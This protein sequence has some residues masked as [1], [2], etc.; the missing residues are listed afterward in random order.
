SDFFYYDLFSWQDSQEPI[1]DIHLSARSFTYPRSSEF[2]LEKVE[3]TPAIELSLAYS[4]G[5]GRE[6]QAK[7]Y[8]DQPD[9]VVRYWDPSTQSVKEKTQ[10]TAWLTT[11]ATQY[12]N[13]GNVIQ[14][15]EPFYSNTYA[16]IDQQALNQVGYSST[17]FYDALDREIMVL[18]PKQY[19][20][21]SLYG[22]LQA[23]SP[24]QETGYLAQELYNT[25]P[26]TYYP[27]SW[28]SL[29]FDVNDAIQDSPY[30]QSASASEQ[31][32][33]KTLPYNTPMFAYTDGLG[34]LI[35]QEQLKVSSNEQNDTYWQR[36]I[37]GNTLKASDGRLLPQGLYNF[38]TTY[39]L[40]KQPMQSASV[41]AGTTWDLW[42]VNEN[43]VY[44]KDAR[45]YETRRLYD[46]L[47]RMIAETV[48]NQELE[49]P[50]SFKSQYVV[51]GESFSSPA[52]WNRRGIP[53]I[54]F[55]QSGLDIVAFQTIDGQ[56]LSALKALCTDFKQSPDWSGINETITNE[57]IQSIE[58]ISNPSETSEINVSMVPKL[59]QE[60]YTTQ[61][62]YNAVDETIEEI[63]PDGNVTS[64]VY[65][66]NG[67]MKNSQID[68]GPS[69]D[70]ITYNARGQRA[71]VNYGNQVVK[72]YSYDPINF[73][74]TQIKSVYTPNEKVIQDYSYTYD[75]LGNVWSLTRNNVP[76]TFFN[77][78]EVKAKAN[79]TYDS[80][81]RLV[82][83]NGRE[84]AGNALSLQQ[85]LLDRSD[86]QY[87]PIPQPNNNGQALQN[88]SEAFT[89]DEGG[90]LTQIKHTGT[91]S[92]TRTHTIQSD[93]NRLKNSVI[94]GE[95]S[96]KKTYAYDA[97]GNMTNLEGA[98][99]WQ[100]NE[101]N[102][103][104][105]AVFV[106]RNSQPD[107][108]EY[109]VYDA[110]GMRVRKVFEKMNNGGKSVTLTDVV[111][112][113]NYE[114]RR[115]Y[116]QAVGTG[117]KT[118]KTDWRVHRFYDGEGCVALWRYYVENGERATSPDQ[119]Q[120]R[121][122]LQDHL[123][124]SNM[125]VDTEGNL[126]TYQEYYPFGGTAIMAGTSQTEVNAKYYQYSF[127][128][129]D[130]TTGLYYY[131]MRYYPSWLGRWINPDPAGTV[132]GLNIYA[133]V[134][135]DPTT[136]MDVGGMT[137]LPKDADSDIDIAMH[138]R[139]KRKNS[140]VNYAD[141]PSDEEFGTKEAPKPKK[142]TG[143]SKDDFY[144]NLAK[145]IGVDQKTALQYVKNDFKNGVPIPVPSKFSSTGEP[146]YIIMGRTNKK[147][148]DKQLRCHHYCIYTA[149]PK[150]SK[151]LT[152]LIGESAASI[153]M[154]GK[155]YKM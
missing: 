72:S 102:N 81:Y 109:Y 17:H 105:A 96:L 118:L 88:Y 121:Y 20:E 146:Q 116:T 12:N 48:E 18:T 58:S 83:A 100:W 23:G 59:E 38:E 19:L 43:E 61:D 131:G 144:I 115:T 122:Q 9:T 49:P 30:Y 35:Q 29:H 133:F 132:D 55:D 78:Q 104:E 92:W 111:Y 126:I 47:H 24:I 107:D 82:S 44:H 101:R 135:G 108:A 3:E 86:Q 52:T 13:K 147:V 148:Q 152:E 87:I 33:L 22:Y 46:D 26:G 53:V 89:Y 85:A 6:V 136:H 94:G 50:L 11:G 42:N 129:R 127:K 37:E 45:G 5:M 128:E 73:R 68:K 98:S 138:D 25:L 75:P 62:N 63:D 113:G 143:G 130:A 124:S 134:E 40:V 70:A 54:H 99:S 95:N 110:S 90:N 112:L 74:L 150:S 141:P 151:D 65:Y 21:K 153:F 36:D 10:N 117:E 154:E 32:Q 51:Y 140:Y 64:T 114:L 28:N 84:H 2:A 120:Q 119:N 60:T 69:V 56:H 123:E 8:I 142:S 91:S 1:Y 93:S 80:L 39:N 103:L 34:H 149:Y 41:D 7:I 67:W 79:Y 31:A 106:P 137:T 155:G 66:L 139:P 145:K 71:V 27:S 57:L 15:F 76:T 14:Q 16:F 97:H 4:D 77:N 125:E